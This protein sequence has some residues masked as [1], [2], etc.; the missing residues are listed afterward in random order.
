MNLLHFAKENN[1]EVDEKA[2]KAV[3]IETYRSCVKI[4]IEYYS[5]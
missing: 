3:M 4:E 2:T 5:Y 1:I